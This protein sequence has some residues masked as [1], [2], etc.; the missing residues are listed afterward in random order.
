MIELR[1][2]RVEPLRVDVDGLED[3][4]EKRFESIETLVE[5]SVRTDAIPDA[6]VDRAG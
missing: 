2:K 1:L 5:L 3:F 4:A 6:L